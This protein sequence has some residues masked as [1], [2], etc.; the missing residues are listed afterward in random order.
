[1]FTGNFIAGGWRPAQQTYFR[2]NPAR[3]DETVAEYPLSG[4]S[5]AM[6]AF[7]AAATAFPKWH[8]TPIIE[9]ARI[10]QRA[11][12]Y[13]IEH[14]ETIARD[15]AL[16]VGKP[17]LEARA[18]VRRA[19]EIFEYYAAWAWQPQGFLLA[20]ARPGT[21]LRARRVPLGVVVLITPWN[22]PIAI[23]A[24]KLAP[25]LLLGNTVVLKPSTLGPRG[26][27]YLARALEAAGLP[28]GVLNLVIGP[29]TPFGEALREAEGVRAVS[30][31]GS[32]EVGFQL[33]AMLA[34]R[35]IRLQLELGG[36]NPFVV[37]EDA[38]LE[39]AARLAAEG[40]FFYAGQKCTATSRVIVHQAIY[41]TF[42]EVFLEAIRKLKVGDPLDE[43]TRVGPLIDAA[44]RENVDRWVRR[45]IAEGGR[46][47]IGGRRQ[48]PGYFYEPTVIEGVSP[49]ASIAQEEIF[50]PVVTLHP[51]SD[52]GE[53]IAIANATRYG[54]S[55]SIVTRRLE[56]AEAFLN[57]VEAG[58]VHVN[59]PTA[60]VEY[61]A[62]FGG[63]KQSGYGPKEQGWSALD[64]Y[65]DWKTL[66]VRV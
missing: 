66:V 45:G 51:A 11:A 1:M 17:I 6:E 48:D 55:A 44:A 52:L 35:P 14:L 25:A 53:A 58:I 54:L 65:S 60:G 23:P 21:E 43:D 49:T 56:V 57:H 5:E 31:T 7:Q 29:G 46:V 59:Q 15:L 64:F 26:A 62:P 39:E 34:D 36:K 41:S 30:F 24:W 50:G 9:R 4:K 10:L 47:L 3:P 22:F 27:V 18:E 33:K 20:S 38:D 40:A 16:E 28:P 37:W 2:K 63:T 19:A 8:R 12:R 42:Q 13:L 61:Q 32:V